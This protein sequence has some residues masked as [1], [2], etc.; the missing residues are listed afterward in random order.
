MKKILLTLAL[1]LT[2]VSII[3]AYA[4]ATAEEE[5]ICD[6]AKD[7]EKVLEAKC[8]IYARVCVV[9]LKTEGFVTKSEYSKF[10]GELKDNIKSEY[11]GIDKVYF[12]RSPKVM[13][14]IS[15]LSNFSDEQRTEEIQ[16]II[17]DILNKYDKGIKPIMPRDLLQ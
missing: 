8:L 9:A 11:D 13:Q 17:Q 16:K 1:I 4:S 5:R 3:P 14:Q 15:R 7:H 12:T 2:F 6:M 10:C